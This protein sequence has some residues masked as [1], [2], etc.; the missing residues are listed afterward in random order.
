MMFSGGVRS[1]AAV[2]SVRMARRAGPGPNRFR[3]TVSVSRAATMASF[4]FA[5]TGDSAAETMRVPICTASAPS[6]K[7]A[8][9]DL[10]STM[11]PA[12]TTGRSICEQISGSSTMVE[13]SL[14]FLK[15]PPS[16]PSTTRPSTPAA[17]AFSAASRD[18]T[19]WK[20]V[21]PADFSCS[22]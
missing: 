21:R 5:W 19:T 17:T 11:P 18:G 12:A 4:Q 1:K 2:F 8:A 22:Q 15:P 3:N 14:G 9:M 10:P 7:A 16:P 20:T 6:A 13:T